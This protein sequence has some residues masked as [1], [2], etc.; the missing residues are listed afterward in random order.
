V[1]AGA[2]GG[3]RSSRTDRAIALMNAVHAV[4]VPML[5]AVP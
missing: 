4:V 5:A 2:L 1:Q 3:S